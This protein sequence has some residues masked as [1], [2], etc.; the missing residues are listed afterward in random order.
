[1]FAC[2]GEQLKHRFLNNA[3][4]AF[5]AVQKIINNI[6]NVIRAIERKLSPHQSSRILGQTDDR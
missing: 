4:V 2:Q 3:Q 6:R 5:W 1:M